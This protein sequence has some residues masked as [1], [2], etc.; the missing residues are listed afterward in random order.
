MW[1][2]VT[3]V[4]SRAASR[5]P[6]HRSNVPAADI[7]TAMQIKRYNEKTRKSTTVEIAHAADV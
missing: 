5:S 7:Q 4:N 3:G 2:K 1:G 6:T